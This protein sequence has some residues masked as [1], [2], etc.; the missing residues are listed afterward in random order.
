MTCD[1][2]VARYSEFVDE[3]LDDASRTECSTHLEECAR[4][5]RYCRVIDKARKVLADL[6]EPALTYDFPHRLRYRLY[7]ERH[8]PTGSSGVSG[9]TLF[10]MAAIMTV[11]A[12]SPTLWTG[13]DRDSVARGALPA[14]IPASEAANPATEWGA[15]RTANL[16]F[17]RDQ[18][19]ANPLPAKLWAD[20]HLLLYRY[21][22][23]ARR[24]RSEGTQ[25][26]TA[27]P[28]S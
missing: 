2:F 5:R 6:P 7:S 3:R 9:T 24:Y 4:C 17:V 15:P 13:T 20:S 22:P 21:S 11:L 28:D 16:M 1:T 23:V 8:R 18:E 25:E 10:A 26:F 14:F 19:E 12:W 27:A